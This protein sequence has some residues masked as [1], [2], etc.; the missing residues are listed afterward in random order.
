M[1]GARHV[2]AV[3]PKEFKR[4]QAQMLGA[5]HTAASL[6][7]A[8]QLVDE[9]TWGR[10][11]D[12]VI[13]CVG[14]VDGDMIAPI[15]ANMVTKNGVCVVTALAP[16]L[17]MDV[18]LNLADL[19][20]QQKSLKGAIFGGGNPRYDI[21]KLLRLYQE[22][23]LKIDEMITNTYSLDQVNEGYEAMRN[24]ENVRGVIVYDT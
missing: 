19:T 3:D 7:E 1:A 5:P 12:Q 15:M 9:I 21:P 2:V 18:K 24:A 11:A 13:I 23:K 14:V 4:E 8:Q 6:E 17:A 22:G 16:A 20:L 10:K